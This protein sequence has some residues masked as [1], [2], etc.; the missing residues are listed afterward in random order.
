[1][2]LAAARV[3]LRKYQALAVMRPLTK[4]E[5]AAVLNVRARIRVLTGNHFA[6]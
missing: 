3:A 5:R 1:M 2:T 6:V 4:V